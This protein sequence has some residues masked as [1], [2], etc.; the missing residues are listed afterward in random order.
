MQKKT[1]TTLVTGLWDLKRGELG[2][3][4]TRGYDHYLECFE[5]LLKLDVNL[6]VFGDKELEDFV[7]KR[8]ETNIQFI[9]RELDWFEN[10][11]FNTIQELRQDDDWYSQVGWLA[12][13]PQAKLEYYNP[14]V[15]SKMMLLHDAKLLDGFNSDYMYWI[16]AGLANTV[17]LDTY[18]NNNTLN[19]ISNKLKDFL[20]V[21]YP[22]NATAEIHGFKYP[23]INKYAGEEVKLVGR[24]GFFGGKKSIINTVMNEYYRL[25]ENTLSAGYMGTEESIFAIMLYKLPDIISY[26]M[27]EENGLLYKVF[28]D[29]IDNKTIV[30]KNKHKDKIEN[31][32]LYVITFNSPNQFETLIKSIELYDKTLLDTK[33]YLLDNSTDDSTKVKYVELCKKY[34]FEMI[35]TGEN[36]GI[37]GGRQYIAEHFD[38]TDLDSYFFFEDDMFF[39]NG[40]ENTCRNGFNRY[41][42]NFFTKIKEIVNEEGFDFLKLNFS[43]FFG[44]NQ[45]Q[46][47]WHNLPQDK[48]DRFFPGITEKP[49]TKYNNIKSFNG[50]PY[51]TGEVYYCNWP[52]LV[53]REGNRKLFLET[54]WEYPYEQTWMS[55][56]YQKTRE[57][58]IKPGIL[59]AT[60]TEHDRFE[61]YDADL[62]REN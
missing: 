55:F 40:K 43:E 44:D 7:N 27:I 48:R 13:S 58:Y 62:R 51:A 12:E 28:Q 15:M 26:H 47:S 22:Y 41:F 34:D 2:N 49:F 17:N 36:I 61:H 8:R 60:P 50:I 52:Q 38:K 53:T 11:F 42:D 1:M 29:A 5:K 16:D 14:V 33:K 37:C 24:G 57:G 45:H 31:T 30:Q 21:T 25:V 20:F 56:I 39:Y 18:V 46:W 4:F 6:I 10:E 35:G 54:T 32:G 23:D 3:N 19:T 59:L 9:Y